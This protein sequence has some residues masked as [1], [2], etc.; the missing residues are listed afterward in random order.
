MFDILVIAQQTIT[1]R[2]VV[3]L[4]VL[5]VICGIALNFARTWI[6]PTVYKVICVIIVGAFCLFLLQFFGLF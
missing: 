6:D 3:L 4:V 1:L 5:L 2:A